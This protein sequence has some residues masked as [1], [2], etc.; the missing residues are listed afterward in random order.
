[1]LMWGTNSK[2]IMKNIK[3]EEANLTH[4]NG[5]AKKLHHQLSK[6]NIF[7]TIKPIQE[8]KVCQKTYKTSP[9]FCAQINWVTALSYPDDITVL[10]MN[11]EI[12]I[13]IQTKKPV[14][15]PETV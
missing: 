12:L 4:R 2:S 11:M 13:S 14:V 15:N 10:L 5:L 7:G 9:T 3:N 1:M 8:E 6:K